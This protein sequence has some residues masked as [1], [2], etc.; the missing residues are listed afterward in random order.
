MRRWCVALLPA[1]LPA[2]PVVLRRW[3]EG[4]LNRLLAAIE[5][6]L[7]ELHRWLPFAAHMPT[8]DEERAVL[9]TATANFDGDRDYA[10]FLIEADSGELVGCCGLHPMSD[11]VAGIGYWA[12][13]D[14]TG[15]GY[16]TAAAGALT[17]AAVEHLPGIDS[18]EIH[19][20][21]ANH[22][23]AAVPARLGYRLVAGVARERLAPGHTGRGLVWVKTREAFNGWPPS[24]VA[25]RRAGPGDLSVLTAQMGQIE[26]FEDRLARQH[27]GRGVLLV[28]VAD[29]EAVGDVYL[30]CE[31]PAEAETRRHLSGVPSLNHLEV[32]TDAQRQGVGARLTL[33][34]EAQAVV[35]GASRVY[36]GVEPD[37]TGARRLYERLGYVE[38][39]HGVVPTG[40]TVT[41]DG[42]NEEYRTVM[43]ILVKQL[44]GDSERILS[45][46]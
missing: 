23:S 7:P 11:A 44:V 33:A 21:A 15:Q 37:N 34:A 22:A 41:R 42:R 39:S 25:V 40:W 28:A 16:A 3:D 2:G 30:W 31:E 45:D 32:R 5:V 8:A 46:P 4:D 43:H 27:E 17:R 6:S 10:Y 20:D 29:T 38:W 14:R 35:R 24:R 36:L 13:T 19:C 18:V 26:F 9:R 1:E 12:R